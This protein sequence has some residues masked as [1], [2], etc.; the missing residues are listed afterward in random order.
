[1]RM[2]MTDRIRALSTPEP[3]TGCWLWKAALNHAGYGSV[4]SR[5]QYSTLAH[6][7]AY[8]A[9]IGPIP[10]PLTV[11]HLCR[12]RSCV[13]PKHLQIVSRVENVMRGDSLPAQRARQ[14]HCWRG[15][16]LTGAN[17]RIRPKG[18]REC[19]TCSRQRSNDRRAAR[20]G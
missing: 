1:M 2:A 10:K 18:H 3:N 6:R 20:R 17:V 19:V 16:A 13:N 15:H 12:V 11:D 8:E 5:G 7:A 14:T 9:F 4:Q